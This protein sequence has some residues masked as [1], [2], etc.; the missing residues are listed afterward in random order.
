MSN[1]ASNVTYITKL[2]IV[3]NQ[4][5][6]AFEIKEGTIIVSPEKY[7]KHKE[8]DILSVKIKNS[9]EVVTVYTSK[10]EDEPY[11]TVYDNLNC[12]DDLYIEID[13]TKY[14]IIKQE[15]VR[16]LQTLHYNHSTKFLIVETIIY[17]PNIQIDPELL[18]KKPDPDE[19][20]RFDSDLKM[21]EALTKVIKDVASESSEEEQDKLIKK[22]KKITKILK[23]E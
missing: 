16:V 4:I 19:P 14:N 3:S 5:F 11:V 10:H 7:L 22:L 2:P 15:V 9:N 13:V 12:Y 8:G 17:K 1:A 20:L 6:E 18:Y 21:F 23:E